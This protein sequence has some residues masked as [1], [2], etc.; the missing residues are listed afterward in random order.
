MHFVVFI[1]IKFQ[2]HATEWQM[3]EKAFDLHVKYN[4]R[5]DNDW[6]NNKVTNFNTFV[7]EIIEVKKHNYP[8]I[9]WAYNFNC[10]GKCCTKSILDFNQAFQV[11]CKIKIDYGTEE[12][13]NY[14]AN[15]LRE[16]KELYRIHDLLDDAFHE[17]FCLFR[18]RKSLYTL[19]AILG[20]KDFYAGILPAPVP[21]W[22]FEL[23]D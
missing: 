11:Y 5:D 8:D 21:I 19:R 18:K 14:Y 15:V 22:R 2:I 3:K 1:L 13:V 16:T 9:A 6:N 23:F 20:E 10:W 17:D 12:Q 4:L 7:N